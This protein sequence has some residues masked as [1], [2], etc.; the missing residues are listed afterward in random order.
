MVMAYN[1]ERGLELDEQIR[2]LRDD[3][4]VPLPDVLLATEL[5]RGCSRTSGRNVPWDIAEALGYNYAFA[6]EFVEL[7]RSSGGG[8]EI[9][10]TCEHGNAVFSR[11][12]IG[13]VGALRHTTNKS[14][15]IPPEQRT[16]D[17]EPR[18]GGRILVYADVL[19][20]E[21]ILHVY[22]LHFE[23][24]PADNDIQVAQAI[25]TAEHG[26]GRRYRVVQGGDT[27]APFYFI[28]LIQETTNDQVTQAFFERGYVD[29]HTPLP[30]DQR[31]TRDG[32]VIDIL[33][34]SSAFFSDPAICS[35]TVCGPLSDHLPLWAT[36]SLD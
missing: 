8:G 19:V 34:G 36:V 12:P 17:G 11:Y 35:D 1:M 13:N 32:L 20:G 6:V 31:G 23:S 9:T 10:G 5:D 30:A 15:Y 28:D 14:W 18:L 24:S 21:R 26:L 7:P 3:P 22:A 33:F 25:E 29:A 16:G 27:N 2:V 4:A